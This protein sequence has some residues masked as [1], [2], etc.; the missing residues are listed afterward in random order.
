MADKIQVTAFAALPVEIWWISPRGHVLRVDEYYF[1]DT[2]GRLDQP[3]PTMP[4]LPHPLNECERVELDG[5]LAGLFLP[6][7][8]RREKAIATHA[9]RAAFKFGRDWPRSRLTPPVEYGAA[10]PAPCPDCG[11]DMGHGA[12]LGK[13]SRCLATGHAAGVAAALSALALRFHHEQDGDVSCI[14]VDCQ[15]VRELIAFGQAVL[16]QTSGLDGRSDV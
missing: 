12:G 15:R 1:A 3:I 11:T 9:A 5:V 6:T 16:R 13:C 7:F 2:E 4:A 10:S 8:S 14:G